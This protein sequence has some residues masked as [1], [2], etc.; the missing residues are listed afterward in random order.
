MDTYH[1]VLYIH[2]ISLLIGFG[3]GA[4]V[5]VCLFKLRSAR[6]VADAAPWGMLAG[7]TERMFPI[8]I[9]GLFG[10]GAYMTSKVWTW[11]TGWIDVAIAVLV[12]LMVQGAGVAGRRAHLLKHALQENGPGPLGA[13][14]KRLT[15]DPALWVVSF[16]NPGMV[17][18]V[19]WAMTEKPS[20]G[21]A[22]VAVVVGYAVG[23]A[24]ALR[25]ARVPAPAA[26]VATEPA[27]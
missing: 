24:L 5:A 19:M 3:A 27:A 2:F 16:A 9:L 20:T 23:A 11:G 8:A 14:A 4:V 17:L 10:S 21:I 26:E 6:T 7:Q 1:V 25:F 22:V 15:C 12:L 13:T 18:G